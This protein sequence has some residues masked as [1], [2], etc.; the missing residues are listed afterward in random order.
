MKELLVIDAGNSRVKY[1]LFKNGEVKKRWWHNTSAPGKEITSTLV[2]ALPARS[3]TRVPVALASVVPAVSEVVTAWCAEKSV[4][5]ITIASIDQT[6]VKGTEGKLGADL[7]AQAAAALKLYGDGKK[8][9]IAISFGTATTLTAVK[10]DGT[11]AGCVFE[12][13]LSTGLEAL[14]ARCALLVPVTAEFDAEP[15]FGFDTE[16]AMRNGAFL[17]HV[18]MVA[19]W[20]R[21]GREIL[22]ADTVV[23]ATGG[24]AN[25][26]TPFLTRPKREGVVDIVDT[27]LTLKGIK[28]LAEEMKKAERKGEQK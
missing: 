22:G 24:W 6:I 21:K 14:S 23:I 10:A 20:V 17:G 11:F 3:R 19:E 25:T 2:K 16:G 27:E 18:G 4:E 8:P 7:T 5:L 13:G 12:L 15:R 26:L 1:A 9:L 28:L